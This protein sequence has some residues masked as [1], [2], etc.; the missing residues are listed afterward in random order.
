MTITRRHF[1]KSTA[2]ATV[3]LVTPRG[4]RGASPPAPRRTLVVVQLAGGNDSLNTLIPYVDKR[5]RSLRP[6]LAIAE[7]DLLPI[8]DRFGLHPALARIQPL[9]KGGSLALIDGVGFP[10][11][12]RSHFRCQDVWQTGD[13][14][15]G[16]D[17]RQRLGWI[18]R[19]ADLH[20]AGAESPL[21]TLAIGNQAALGM[22]ARKRRPAV[23]ADLAHFRLPGGGEDD[24]LRA[25]RDIYSLPRTEDPLSDTIRGCGG[26]LFLSADAHQRVPVRPARAAYPESPLGEALRSVAAMID[27]HA[28]VQAAWVTSGGFD[29]HAKQAGDHAALLSDLAASLAAFQ[30]DIIARS[31][32]EQVVLMAWSEFGRRAAENASAGTDHGKAGIVFVMGRQVR[33]GLYGEPPDLSRLDAGDVPPRVD[34]RSV[35]ATLIRNWYRQ[36]PEPVLGHPYP[37]L[38]FLRT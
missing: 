16:R 24:L 8:D 6:T 29:T 31:L 9:Y 32:G 22:T 18:G 4:L 17:H 19:Y 21:V 13:E 20:L 37:I 35:Y 33:G 3:V 10:S 38:G 25:L 26:D 12:D 15:C 23:I 36:D 2:A 11:L 30:S 28:E 27:A 34:F 7:R 14:G 1:L 5:Y